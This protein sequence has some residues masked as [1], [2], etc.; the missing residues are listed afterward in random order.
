MDYFYF[1]MLTHF[2]S[3]F[4]FQ[5]GSW[6]IEKTTKF[7]PLLYH[8]IQ[9]TVLFLAIFYFLGINLLW[10][11]WIFS[12]HLLIDNR[13]FLNWFNHKLKKDPKV[14]MWVMYVQDNI[15][16]LLVLIPILIL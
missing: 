8:S 3:D 4:F 7:K 6:A 14:P 11:L 16:H 15:I 1:L 9:Y 10:G 13:K 2:A 12:T 5:P